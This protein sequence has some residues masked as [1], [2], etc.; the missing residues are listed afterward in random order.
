[1]GESL[2]P[3]RFTLSDHPKRDLIKHVIKL[4]GGCLLLPTDSKDVKFRLNL[5]DKNSFEVDFFIKTF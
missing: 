3:I 4:S 2:Q 5:A 1:M